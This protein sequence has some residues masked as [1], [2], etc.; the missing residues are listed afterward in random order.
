MRITELPTTSAP[1]STDFLAIDDATLGTRKI[2]PEDL[3]YVAYDAAQTLTST[4]AAQAR[5][6]IQLVSAT[7]S[8]EGLVQLYDGVDS[9]STALAATANAVR[10]AYNHGGGGSG[11][12]KNILDNPYFLNPVNQRGQN[13]YTGLIYTIDRWKLGRTDMTANVTSNG[14]NIVMSGT[15]GRVRQYFVAGLYRGLTLTAS[16]LMSDGTLLTG[17]ATAPTADNQTVPFDTGYP[18]GY[19]E[20]EFE[21]NISTDAFCIKCPALMNKTMVAAKLEIGQS[22]TLC[23]DNSGWKL[24]EIPSFYEELAK[25]QFYFYR[26]KTNNANEGL[27]TCPAWSTQNATGFF[28]FPVMRTT[29]T[30][31]TSNAW[32][33]TGN[34]TKSVNAIA[35]N[36]VPYRYFVTL[37]FTV[38]SGLTVGNFYTFSSPNADAVIDFSADL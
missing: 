10:L 35:I 28:S 19:P 3:G 31:S 4:Q 7:T 22:Q 29:P 1:S 37:D 34:V 30:I 17:T 26:A 12:G 5:D 15:L 8:D 23:V 36:Y 25:C 27:V 32:Q 6:N 13:T 14:L 20:L 33:L 16:V 18:S 21:T 2:A 11:I 24:T 38:S 9:S